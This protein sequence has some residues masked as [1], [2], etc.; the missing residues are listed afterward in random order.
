LHGVSPLVAVS[1]YLGFHCPLPSHLVLLHHLIYYRFTFLLSPLHL[2]PPYPPPTPPRLHTQ[3]LY[4][5]IFHTS[6]SLFLWHPPSSS[7]LFFQSNHAAYSIIFSYNIHEDVQLSLHLHT[8]KF[9][10]ATLPKSNQILRFIFHILLHSFVVP[11][12]SC[13]LVSFS[14][15]FLILF[16]SPSPSS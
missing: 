2:P 8:Y 12:D 1:Y 10:S 11:P 14:H 15:P 6:Y 7:P 5:T 3:S 13:F 9:L 4:F 16:S